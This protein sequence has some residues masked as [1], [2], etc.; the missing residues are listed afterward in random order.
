M[1][2]PLLTGSF[3]VSMNPDDL[4]FYLAPGIQWSIFQ[5]L[6]F[7]A[8]AQLFFGDDF[9]LYGDDSN[10]LLAFTFRWSFGS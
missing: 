5:N 2:T 1:F 7:S 9:T 10:H 3:A 8:V 4:S 6:D